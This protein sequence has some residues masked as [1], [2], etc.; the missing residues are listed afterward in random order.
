MSG[1]TKSGYAMGDLVK[2]LQVK[3]IFAHSGAAAAG[4]TCATLLEN[5]ALKIEQIVSHYHSSPEGFWY[6]QAWEEWVI[7][8]RG[9]AALEFPGGETLEMCEGDYLTIP[10]HVKHRVLRTGPETIWLSVH[11]K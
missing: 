8:L 9:D 1:R 5:A 11:I 3:N 10:R 6:D 7:V 4:E 2:S